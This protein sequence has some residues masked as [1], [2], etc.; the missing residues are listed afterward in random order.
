MVV[1]THHLLLSLTVV[2]SL[3]YGLNYG[4]NDNARVTEINTIILSLGRNLG[5]HV[6]FRLEN[7]LKA[8]GVT[9]LTYELQPLDSTLSP[10]VCHELGR[11][12]LLLGLGNSTLTN[13]H[14]SAATQSQQNLAPESFTML[15][16]AASRLANNMLPFPVLVTDGLPRER[17]SHANATQEEFRKHIE[18]GAVVGSYHTLEHIGFA[19][20]HP[21]RPYI[22]SAIII[23]TSGAVATEVNQS[24]RW[25]ERN[26]HIHTQHP[27]EL[28]EVL[29][30]MDV[31]ML[32]K[33]TLHA[34]C[35]HDH[36]FSDPG[37]NK[38]HFCERW[39]DMV[40]EVDSMFEWCA[41]N[42]LNKVNI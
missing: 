24:P 17:N 9:V 31:P 33:G 20:L 40:S 10:T 26:F 5:K 27:L 18:Y 4:D 23:N 30:G 39:E 32:G 37:Q 25:P 12:C 1:L 11:S 28:N 41:A 38:G 13:L 6:S 35:Q 7:H 19:F 3:G 36:D 42:K 8:T 29:Q 34:N 22:P 14:L 15:Q 21:L 16:K 2:I